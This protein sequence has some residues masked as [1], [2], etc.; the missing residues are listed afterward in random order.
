MFL[1]QWHTTLGRIPKVVGEDLLRK[2][3]LEQLR[4]CDCMGHALRNYDSADP[5]DEKR[6]YSYLLAQINRQ[7]A[8]RRQRENEEAIKTKL[9]GRASTAAP[10]NPSQHSP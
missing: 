8:L 6:S 9:M 10:V 7:L 5:G 4:N 3:F 1:N 2:R